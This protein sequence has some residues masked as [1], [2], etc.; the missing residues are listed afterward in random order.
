MSW[1]EVEH[2][3]NNCADGHNG[4]KLGELEEQMRKAF[5]EQFKKD[6]PIKGEIGQ[7]RPTSFDGRDWN[8]LTFNEQVYGASEY[9]LWN[10]RN[11]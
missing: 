6:I 11:L 4:Y 1:L 10:K 8:D 9:G 7:I 5:Y 2:K 3:A